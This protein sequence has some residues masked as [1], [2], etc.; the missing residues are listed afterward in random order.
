M[1]DVRSLISATTLSL[2]MAGT[3]SIVSGQEACLDYAPLRWA[4]EEG[5]VR[6]EAVAQLDVV[7]G[8]TL[9]IEIWA[10]PQGQWSIIAIGEDGIACIIL[11]G[12]GWTK[13]KRL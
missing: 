6:L 9:R 12:A 11:S 3:P 5:G 10:S 7:Y 1:M 13:P 8:L 4:M 2:V